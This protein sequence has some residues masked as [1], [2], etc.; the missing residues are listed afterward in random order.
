MV[1]M[2]NAKFKVGMFNGK[3]K[4]K[5]LKLKIWDLLMQQELHKALNG[6]REE[7]MSMTDKEG[8]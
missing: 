7:P 1:N 5:L 8:E 4:F 3:N 2:T 6:K